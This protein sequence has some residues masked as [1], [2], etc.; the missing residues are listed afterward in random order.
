MLDGQR[1]DCVVHSAA[2]IHIGWQRMDESLKVN[3]EGTRQVLD[4]AKDSGTRVVYVSTVNCLPLASP[5]KPVSEND[6]GPEQIPCA[7]VVSKNAAQQI[8][9]EAIRRGDDCY[10]VYPGFMLGPYDWQLSSGRMIMALQSFCC[11]APSGGCSVCDPRDVASAI[12]RIAREGAPERRYILAGENMTYFD[13][14]TVIAKKL[15]ARPP[16]IAMRKP[17]RVIGSLLADTYNRL[18]RTESDFNS[19]AIKMGQ[20]FHYYDSGRA[21]QDLDYKNRPFTESID[22]SIDWL[23]QQGHLRAE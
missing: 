5:S 2:L 8:C 7:Y 6:A 22:D 12:L 21:R 23:R 4:W 17:A 13:L 9:D 18:R 20:Q 11:W 3:R 10:C 14:W 16:L 15:G 19:A 1:F